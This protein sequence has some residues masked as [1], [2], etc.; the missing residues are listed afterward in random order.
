MSTICAV[1]ATWLN[2]SQASFCWKEQVCPGMNGLDTA[3]YKNVLL[4]VFLQ[5]GNLK[6][7]RDALDVNDVTSVSP[8]VTA[9]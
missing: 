8:A 2:G 7:I 4:Y 9:S 1:I 5:V 3:L 6:G